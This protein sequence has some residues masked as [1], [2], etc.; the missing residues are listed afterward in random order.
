[1]YLFFSK[2]KFINSQGS[3]D[4][5]LVGLFFLIRLETFPALTIPSL[6]IWDQTPSQHQAV[7]QQMLTE[8]Q[9]PSFPLRLGLYRMVPYIRPTAVLIYIE[10]THIAQVSCVGV[11]S[12]L[13]LGNTGSHPVV[14]CP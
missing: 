8:H 2:M 9:F 10:V 3:E 5:T 13:G 14:V 1:M 12:C 7:T 11:A 6:P 4:T